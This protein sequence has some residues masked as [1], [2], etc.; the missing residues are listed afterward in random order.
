MNNEEVY[1][2]TNFDAYEYENASGKI[3]FK[4]NPSKLLI[5]KIVF[6]SVF[7][8]TT[9]PSSS[10]FPAIGRFRNL[11][12]NPNKPNLSVG[13]SPPVAARINQHVIAEGFD[14]SSEYELSLDASFYR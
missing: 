1:S 9:H 10:I 5:K 3:C 11:S 13:Q 4:L 12:F 6:F 7:I 14:I 2:L 8:S